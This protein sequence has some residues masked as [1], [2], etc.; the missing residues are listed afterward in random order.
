MSRT[1]VSANKKDGT[2]TINHDGTTEQPHAVDP[3]AVVT[4]NGKPAKLTDLKA[5]DELT[6]DGDPIASVSAIR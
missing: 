3:D 2:I 1:F 5:G 6:Y 4:L